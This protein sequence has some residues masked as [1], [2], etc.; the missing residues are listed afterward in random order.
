MLAQPFA[1]MISRNN[2]SINMKQ[3]HVK[4]SDFKSI[5]Y[6]KPLR[7]YKKPRFGIEDRVR[8]FKHDLPFRKSYKAQFTQEIFENVAIATKEPPTFTIKDEEEELIRGKFYE[9]EL[10][11]VI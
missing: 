7:E 8:I 9:Q 6:S 5:L 10:I 4:N 3:N 2:P 1:T 11:R